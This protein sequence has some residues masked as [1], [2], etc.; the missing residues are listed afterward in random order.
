MN[1]LGAQQGFSHEDLSQFMDAQWW[2]PITMGT[3]AQK[4]NVCFDTGSSNL[5]VPTKSVNI[6]GLFKNKYRSANSST[7]VANGDEMQIQYGSGAIKGIFSKDTLSFGGLNVQGV[8]FGEIST[9]SWNFLTSRFDGILGL[10]WK[11]ISVKGYDTIFDKIGQQSLLE[12]NSFSFYLAETGSE[13]IIGGVDPAYHNGDFKYFPLISQSYWLIGGDKMNFAGK[14]YGNNDLKLIVDSGTSLIVGDTAL[15]ADLLKDVPTAPDCTKIDTYPDLTFT[16]GGQ[17]YVLKARDYILQVKV[18]WMTQCIVGIQSMDF[19]KSSIGANAVIL[20]D[21]FMRKY[22][23]HF[24]I[25]NKRV[26]F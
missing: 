14:N 17:D 7:Y 24:D 23:S 3:P 19:S 21:V 6:W 26:G 18:L 12:D 4:F 15:M 8:D 13:L 10:G 25:T 11:S 9:L 16:I 1:K 22:Y 5:W 20:G 2:G